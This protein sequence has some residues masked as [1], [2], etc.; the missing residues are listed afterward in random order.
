MIIDDEPGI[1]D[2]LFLTL[3]RQ[4]ASIFDMMIWKAYSAPE[5]LRI[6]EH[7]R[8]DIV[9]TDIKMP[10]MTGIELVKQM[11]MYWKD[12]GV[13]FISGFSD[14]EY[15]QFALKNE[16]FD[17]LLKP[18]DDEHLMKVLLAAIEKQ[19]LQR[20]RM[21]LL[22]EARADIAKV[23]NLLVR[24]LLA[25]VLHGNLVDKPKIQSRADWLGM[26][27]QIDDHLILMLGRFDDW[28]QVN[29]EQENISM[30]A[31][32]K[33]VE[34]CLGHRCRLQF[35]YENNVY[36]WIIQHAGQSDT[37]FK[38]PL[39]LLQRFVVEMVEI[40]QKII[41]EDLHIRMSFV[42]SKNGIHWNDLSSAFMTLRNL[43][44]RGI[45]LEPEV[46]LIEDATPSRASD[47]DKP[48]RDSFRDISKILE[49]LKELLDASQQK[50]FEIKLTCLFQT[51]EQSVFVDTSV[52][53]WIFNSL[54][55]MMLTF[56]HSRNVSGL[57]LNRS[58]IELLGNYSEHAGWDR[59]KSFY[60]G[61][62][63]QLFASVESEKKSI[64]DMIIRKIELYIVEHIGDYITLQLVANH[65]NL[66]PY[67]VSHLY[68]THTGFPLSEKIMEIRLAKAK[69]LL[70]N[71]VLKIH[72]VADQVGLGST[73]YFTKLFKK[74]TGLTPSE[75]RLNVIN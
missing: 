33:I 41:R 50:Q 34:M 19:K 24:E 51:V 10:G 38:P 6:L 64:K 4:D 63:S 36:V 58:H 35:Y 25:E 2:N 67:Y 55:S 72:E 43:L 60:T 69:E 31:V 12:C 28:I 23:K 71:D 21:A 73:S 61:L 17:Y 20:S 7:N 47:H 1:V 8:I 57:L 44:Q 70:R 68:K 3:S 40:I 66:N 29:G 32:H 75:Y 42:I 13:I 26:D 45:G 18:V 52:Q 59:L 48:E 16:A 27:L 62:S 56:I 65:V 30:V 9:I 39:L 53:I 37:E 22:D 46:V 15:L 74:K 14:Y 49:S 11:R 54:S 5:A